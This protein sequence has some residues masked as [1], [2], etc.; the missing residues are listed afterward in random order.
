MGT[1]VI[2]GAAGFL[3]SHLCDRLIEQN[4]QV[5]GVDDFSTGS[6]ANISHLR[7]SSMF[8]FIE[9]DIC[10]GFEVNEAVD[11][12]LNFAS[13][14]SPPQYL[15]RPLH[16]LRTSSIGAEF[17][18]ELSVAN[19]ARFIQASTS[20][21]YG[22][23]EVHPQTES[24]RGSVSSTGPR[25][26]YDEG[27]RY[28]EALCM[29]Y[30]RER[31][32]DV[33]I[34]R[35]F[36]TYGPRLAAAD[37]RVVSNFITQALAGDPLTIYGAGLQTRSFCYVDDLVDGILKLLRSDETGPVNLGNP[38]EVSIVELAQLILE[39]IDSGSKIEFRDLPVDDPTRRCPDISLASSKLGWKPKVDLK[40]GLSRTITWFQSTITST[41]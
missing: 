2:L 28:A 17:A 23:P 4:H 21:V 20:E 30:R 22:D 3:G 26:C 5:I 25:S 15:Q 11:A 38:S 29:A 7:K 24:Y 13:P 33:G 39:L 40:D 37:G 6:K 14:A 10:D 19:D 32:A 36:N 35:I 41:S 27:K 16:T 1:T 9:A 8:R 12:V 31:G 34:A 18:L